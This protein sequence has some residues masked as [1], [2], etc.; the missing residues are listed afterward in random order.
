MSY[1]DE[2]KHRDQQKIQPGTFAPNFDGKR[3]LTSKK[4]FLERRQQQSISV[5]I[6]RQRFL[7]KTQKSSC[8]CAFQRLIAE[9]IVQELAGKPGYWDGSGDFR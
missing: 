3:S 5:D 2:T 4:S 1:N 8:R 7:D 6:S 9:S